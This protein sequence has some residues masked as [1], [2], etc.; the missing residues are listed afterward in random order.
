MKITTLLFDLDGTLLPMDQDT[1]IKAYFYKISKRLAKFGYDPEKLVKAIWDGTMLMVKN[2]GK[3]TNEQVFWD[4]MAEIFGKDVRDDEPKFYDFYVEEFD[5]VAASCGFTP[6]AREVVDLA[7]SLGLRTALATN[8]IFPAIATEKRVLWAGLDPKDF[9]LITT[10]ENSRHSKPNPEYYLDILSQLGLRPEECVMIGNDAAEDTVPARLG[11][12]V[13]ILT[14]DLINKTDVDI[15][16]YPNGSFSELME[17]IRS[18]ER[19]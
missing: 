6:H 7:H 3:R 15:T 19:E 12:K 17:F 18:L 10:Y 13:F 5:G 1:F 11:M 16:Q 8:P 2:D 14:D 9:E 4:R